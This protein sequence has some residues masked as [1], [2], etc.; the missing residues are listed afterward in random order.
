MPDRKM[1]TVEDL[2][3]SL[4]LKRL[5]GARHEAHS[6]I[7]ADDLPAGDPFWR[8]MFEH[9]RAIQLLIDSGSGSIVDANPEACEFYGYPRDVFRTLKIWDINTFSPEEMQDEIHGA[10]RDKRRFFRLEHRLGSGAIRQVEV[11]SAQLDL[12][13]RKIVHSVIQDITDRAS[14]EESRAKLEA[15]LFK[16]QELAQVG[17]WYLD[18]RTGRVELSDT[19]NRILGYVPGEVPTTLVE[20]IT[21]IQ[22]E[23]RGLFASSVNGACMGKAPFDL[24]YR[25]QRGGGEVRYVHAM[26]Q[27]IRNAEGD[28]TGLVGAI[29]DITDRKRFEMI[30][31]EK[32][33]RFRA[34]VDYAHDWESWIG[35]DGTLLWVNPAVRPHTGYSVEE[36]LAMEGY[37][38][39]MVHPEDRDAVRKVLRDAMTN[40]T[41]GRDH[42]FRILCKHGPVRWMEVSW[43]P[44]HDSQGVW[45]GLRTSA[46]DVSDRKAAER[47]LQLSEARYKTLF[48]SNPLFISTW[49]VSGESF[50]LIDYNEAARSIIGEELGWHLA[51]S[52]EEIYSESPEIAADMQTCFR[53]RRSLSREWRMPGGEGC[54]PVWQALHYAYVA[55]DMVLL[56]AENITKRKEAERLREDVDRMTRHDLK[57][58]LMG[59]LSVP[60]L[61]RNTMELS[62]RQELWLTQLEE[63]GYKMMNMINRS[64]DLYKMETGRYTLVPERVDL[65]PVV[66]RVLHDLRELARVKKIETGVAVHG[67]GRTEARRFQVLGDEFLFYSLFANLIKNA[68]EASPS[69][70]EIEVVLSRAP[71]PSVRITNHGEVP[72]NI[73]A[74]FFEKYVSSGKR[75]GTG[76]GTYSARLIAH[77]LGGDVL[78]DTETPDKTSVTVVLPQ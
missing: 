49:Q 46:R 22:P 69:G 39:A 58:P 41:A 23:N 13:G 50:I 73:R 48:L 1:E 68:L 42:S 6:P 26:A 31:R 7:D 4:N 40:R 78:L 63:S 59:V 34:I 54:G 12:A 18:M 76:L 29:Q 66:R 64:L 60:R 61:L 28:A 11:Y 35:P 30:L 8:N 32:E 74:T 16:A 19:C 43:H 24:E 52:V 67:G 5:E 38:A 65:L 21:H 71:Q 62:E 33:E 47:A 20:F 17:S 72:D 45:Q 57:T 77:A 70:L 53:D 37:P 10:R 3:H 36:C 15:S 9:S 56:Q 55:P 27:A 14:V 44:I 25:I 51:R 2:I 75:F